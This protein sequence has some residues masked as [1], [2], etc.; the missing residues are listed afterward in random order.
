MGGHSYLLS[1]C[2]SHRLQ[3]SK[4]LPF[5]SPRAQWAHSPKH[6]GI[7]TGL[8][9]WTGSNS[10]SLEARK[11]TSPGSW[12]FAKFNA[13]EL[14]DRV[15]ESWR[16]LRWLW[17]QILTMGMWTNSGQCSPKSLR[18][19]SWV[20][21]FIPAHP[22]SSD[23]IRVPSTEEVVKDDGFT[24]DTPSFLLISGSSRHILAWKQGQEYFAWSQSF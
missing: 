15:A 4:Q 6:H 19:E 11:C 20:P 13:D 12:A 21:V 8:K 23:C 2:P 10:S 18:A 14:K 16:L 22:Q 24:S 3:A 1:G 5:E 7:S 9:L 17:S